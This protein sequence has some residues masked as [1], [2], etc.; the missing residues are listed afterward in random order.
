MQFNK[1]TTN[2]LPNELIY[3]QLTGFFIYSFI[4]TEVKGLNVITSITRIARHMY[5]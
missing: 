1:S 4:H 3:P 5:I 2:I